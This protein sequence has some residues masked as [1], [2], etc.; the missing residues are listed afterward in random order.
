M[1]MLLEPCGAAA[2][3]KKWERVQEKLKDR[4][5]ASIMWWPIMGEEGLAL[6]GAVPDAA[7]YREAAPATAPAPRLER[8]ALFSL[9]AVRRWLGAGPEL[10][11]LDLLP[12][13]IWSHS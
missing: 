13:Q 5:L 10:G 9:R 12:L 3:G 6:L 7:A 1:Q 2:H 4:I 8:R 11:P